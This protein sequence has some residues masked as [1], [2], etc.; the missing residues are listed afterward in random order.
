MKNYFIFSEEGKNIK[1]SDFIER[2]TNEEG[3]QVDIISEIQNQSNNVDLFNDGLGV[4]GNEKSESFFT[5]TL[6][7]LKRAIYPKG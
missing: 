6:A 1:K 2:K 5:S 7:N 3:H 4:S